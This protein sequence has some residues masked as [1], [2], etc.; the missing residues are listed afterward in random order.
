MNIQID[1][2]VR[3]TT[4]CN[5]GFNCLSGGKSCLCSVQYCIAGELHFVKCSK[6]KPCQYK[7]PFA[8]SFICMCPTR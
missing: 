2:C 4:N 6:R 5:K 3:S 8:K 1:E 7:E